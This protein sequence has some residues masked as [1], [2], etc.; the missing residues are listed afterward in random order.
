M[1]P[2]FF[3]LFP[4]FLSFLFFPSSFFSD[5]NHN[6][7]DTALTIERYTRVPRLF[8]SFL[9]PPFFSLSS[10]SRRIWCGRR[11]LNV[12]IDRVTQVL[13]P[14]PPPLFFH[15]RLE[16]PILSSRIRSKPLKVEIFN[17]PSLSFCFFFFFF[18]SPSPQ[19]RRLLQ[20]RLVFHGRT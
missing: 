11:Q 6:G 19:I 10:F 3:H 4:L 2:P 8:L 7:V 15:V 1:N 16:R 13:P 17:F 14:S 12:L 5:Q 18:F 9:F 20:R